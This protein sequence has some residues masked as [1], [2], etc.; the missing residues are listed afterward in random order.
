MYKQHLLQNLEREILLLKQIAPLIKE[1]DLQFRPAEKVR[2]MLEMM[3]YLSGI[4]ST[5]LRWFVKNDITKEEWQKIREYRSTLTL[6]NFE[7]RL[8]E[9]WADIQKYMDE[10]TEEDLV[11]KIVELPS[12]EKMVLGAAII[13]APIKWLTA[14]RMELF[15]YLKITGHSHISTREA[16][17]LN[18]GMPA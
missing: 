7:L 15:L 3:Q 10:I 11:T 5:M 6:Q 9:Q 17:N 2:S 4:G 18:Q 1:E 13:N 16:W 12:K 8:D 14:Y